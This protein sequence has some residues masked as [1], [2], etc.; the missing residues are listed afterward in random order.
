M[1]NFLEGIEI[2][3]KIAIIILLIIFLWESKKIIKKADLLKSSLMETQIIY[4]NLIRKFEKCGG[5]K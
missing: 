5:I 3:L 4:E 2:G 1:N